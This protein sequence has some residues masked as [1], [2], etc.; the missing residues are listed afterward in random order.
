MKMTKIAFIGTGNMAS[1]IVNGVIKSNIVSENQIILFD[2]NSEQYKRF[3]SKC[4]T[5]N[6][7]QK[8]CEFANYIFLSVK[9]QNIKEILCE[10]KDADINNKV[11][12]SICA[13]ITIESIEKELKGTKIIRTMPNT[14]LLI[15]QG[16]TALC[17]NDAVTDEEFAF[18]TSLF[19]SSGYTAELKESEINAIT[20]VTSSSPAYI[21]Y[22]IK[23]ML[24]G[25]KKLGLDGDNL[26]EMICR[27]FIGASNMVLS[28]S[29][30]VD[31]LIR[32]VKSPNGTTEKAL[33]VFEDECVSEIIEKAMKACADRA[34]E[35]S[36]L[37]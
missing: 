31:E 12:V 28:D 20:A 17:R 26:L 13:G 21:Y 3:P 9:P 2:K 6:S 24:D 32:M 36:K 29:R 22:F 30:S 33:N 11:F 19:A 35:L 15:G 25:A 14:P 34:D 16:V 10:L 8:I 18:V 27:T 5:A 1:A 7:V 37:N 23:S 4:N